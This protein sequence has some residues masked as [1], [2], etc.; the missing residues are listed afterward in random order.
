MTLQNNKDIHM[1]YNFD[2]AGANMVLATCSFL[3]VDHPMGM[4]V[5]A[6]HVGACAY[7]S[8]MGLRQLSFVGCFF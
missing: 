3:A 6:G 1:R 4:S 8:Y 7:V 5:L 2:G